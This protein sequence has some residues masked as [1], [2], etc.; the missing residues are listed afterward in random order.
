MCTII[1][2][3]GIVRSLHIKIKYPRCAQSSEWFT[4]IRNNNKKRIYSIDILMR[5]LW[6][7]AEVS[8]IF[9]TLAVAVHFYFSILSWFRSKFQISTVSI[10][11]FSTNSTISFIF[12]YIFL[13][14]YLINFSDLWINIAQ[15]IVVVKIEDKRDKNSWNNYVFW[16]IYKWLSKEF[17]AQVL[18]Y[19]PSKDQERN[20]MLKLRP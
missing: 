9:I 8:R 16:S 18:F 11:D 12:L 20:R 6:L 10:K 14:E 15:E 7:T 1:S 3:V 17:E 13:F 5:L 4:F 19:S 2:F